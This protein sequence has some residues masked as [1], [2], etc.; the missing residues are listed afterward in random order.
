MAITTSSMEQL[1]ARSP[2]PFTAPSIW[3]A[4]AATAARELATASPR[5]LWLWVEK[6]TLSAPGTRSI[7]MAKIRAM[8][9][10]M[11]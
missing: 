8:S 4:P 3:R 1:P 2:M 11:A 5:S 6:I 7:S 10:G 9:V